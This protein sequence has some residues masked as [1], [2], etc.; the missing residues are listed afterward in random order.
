LVSPLFFFIG[1]P[2]GVADRVEGSREGRGGTAGQKIPQLREEEE[3]Q[4]RHRRR[5][6][7]R[8]LIRK[9]RLDSFLFFLFFL[10][11]L[12]SAG[13]RTASPGG[14][15]PGKGAKAEKK[16]ENPFFRRIDPVERTDGG[17]PDLLPSDVG[18]FN[19]RLVCVCAPG[20]SGGWWADALD[21][22]ALHQSPSFPVDITEA[23]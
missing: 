11:N 4:V 10:F 16:S 22:S 2:A 20:R 12:L 23:R 6:M 8:H 17:S 9:V 13:F 14:S 1:S 5:L 3:L 21:V 19:P 15:P 7:L 18:N